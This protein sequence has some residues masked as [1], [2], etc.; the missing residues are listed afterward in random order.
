MAKFYVKSGKLSRVVNAPTV[1]A[2]V[3]SCL[4]QWTGKKLSKTIRV[5]EVGFDLEGPHHKKDVILS[6]QAV[7]DLRK[8][9]KQ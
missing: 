1:S 3:E 6:T 8:R 7:Q 2:A 4:G 9:K 5:S